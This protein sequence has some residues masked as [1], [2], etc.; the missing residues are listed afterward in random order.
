MTV[1]IGIAVLAA[2]SA[3]VLW[4]G[5]R[6]DRASLTRRDGALAILRDQLAEVEADRERG[7]IS[8]EEAVAAR[9]EIERRLLRAGRDGAGPATGP[10]GVGGAV[11]VT[12]AVPLAA[13]L[14]YAQI[15]APGVASAPLSSRSAE[16]ETNAEVEGLLRQLTERLEAD[17]EG[18]PIQGWILLGQTY[19][20]QWRYAEA[21]A[22]FERASAREGADSSVFSR[23]AEA[24]IAAEDGVVTP[25]AREAIDRAV[26]LDPANPAATFYLALAQEQDGALV[27]AR[28]TLIARLAAAEGFGPWMEPFVA[29]ANRIGEQ[30]GAEPVTLA[31]LGM[32]GTGPGPDAAAVAAASEMSGEDRA[33][34]IRSMVDGLAARLEEDPTDVEGW[35]RLIRAYEVLGEDEALANARVRARAAVLALPEDDARRAGLLAAIDGA[36]Q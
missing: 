17:P 35:L 8:E 5:T 30:I 19:M 13:I 29:S 27:A 20:R 32:T 11:L 4:L 34:F 22:A 3:A 31:S 36:G 24:L 23:Y 15:G 18:G 6:R 33:A 14:L 21:V 2:I 16:L 7:V 26:T 10:A 1:W 12:A 25:R 9:V 28:E